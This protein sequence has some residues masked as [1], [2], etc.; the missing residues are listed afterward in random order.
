MK[1]SLFL[2]PTLAVA[3][4]NDGGLKLDD[5]LLE[6]QLQTDCESQIQK[7]LN[8]E[9]ANRKYCTGDDNL[10]AF[11]LPDDGKYIFLDTR[12]LLAYYPSMSSLITCL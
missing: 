3:F 11:C 2:L 6:R 10:G 7:L 9:N 1:L 12:L 8:C 5:G 4:G